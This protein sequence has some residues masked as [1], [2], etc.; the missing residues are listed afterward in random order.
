M[1]VRRRKARLACHEARIAATRDQPGPIA[2]TIVLFDISPAT[3]SPPSV[4]WSMTVLARP[5]R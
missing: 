3:A 5:C 4:H 2:T 1:R